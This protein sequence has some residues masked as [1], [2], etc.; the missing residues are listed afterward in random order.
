MWI[1]LFVLHQDDLILLT[2]KTKRAAVAGWTHTDPQLTLRIPRRGCG[3]ASRRV[4]G[5]AAHD[6]L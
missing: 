5:S 1:L 4:Q 2:I 3:S 6:E